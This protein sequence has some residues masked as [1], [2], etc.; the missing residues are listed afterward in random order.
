[1]IDGWNEVC[2]H[3][4]FDWLQREIAA[5]AHHLEEVAL[6]AGMPVRMKTWLGRINGER[7]LERKEIEK[8]TD[9]ARFRSDGRAGIAGTLHRLSSIEQPGGLITGVRFRVGRFMPNVA[10][11]LLPYLRRDPYAAIVGRPGGG[12]TTVLRAIAAG[13]GKIYGHNLV[14]IEPSGEIGGSGVDLYPGMGYITRFNCADP[15]RQEDTFIRA[16]RNGSP[17]VLIGDEVGYARDVEVIATRARS[18]C[19]V[20]CTVHGID[21][22]DMMQNSNL[23]VLLGDYDRIAKK[24]H[25]TAP[26]HQLIEVLAKG[27]YRVYTNLD[28]AIDARAE[29]REPVSELVGD[30]VAKFL[31]DFPEWN[32]VCKTPTLEAA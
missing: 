5:Q 12:K 29:R 27:V 23:P 18:G 10:D 17:E 25:S 15:M 9:S 24:R 3:F 26:V 13:L 6:D 1:M 30:N 7:I 11:A 32:G 4:P 16:V 28:A 2:K 31:R 22:D 14:I 19:G 8:I 20:I 21:L